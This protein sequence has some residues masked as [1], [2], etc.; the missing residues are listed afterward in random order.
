MESNTL[1]L[2][3]V[4][5]NYRRE[6]FSLTK[7]K[8]SPWK[9]SVPLTRLPASIKVIDLPDKYFNTFTRASVLNEISCHA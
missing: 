1:F 6:R 7:L 4:S 5:Q 2:P 9:D 8:S 3:G